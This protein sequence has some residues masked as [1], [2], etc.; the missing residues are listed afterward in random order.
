MSNF[1]IYSQGV[2]S[3]ATITVNTITEDTDFPLTNLQDRDENTLMKAGNANTSG[4]LQI[5]L[6]AARAVDYIILGNHNYTNT[7]VG[8]VVSYCDDGD[9]DFTPEVAVVGSVG[10]VTYHNYVSANADRWFE[11]F[12]QATKRYWRIY[13]QAM[14]AATNQEIGAIFMG[15][16]WNWAHEPELNPL[17]NS[18]YNVTIN[19]AAG[20]S[21][22]S[23]I[24]NTTVRRIWNYPLKF[25]SS[26]EKTNHETWRDNIFMNL[27]G[28]LSRYPF[29]W[30]EDNGVTINFARY[31]GKLNLKQHAYQQW[32]TN[33]V[34][35]EEL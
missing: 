28:G 23:Q 25:I 17:D 4:Y 15:A 1:E 16:Q 18:G 8:I 21:T 19:Q 10:P 14:G 5:D 11:T 13:L 6:A 29:Y 27:N 20:G 30:S 2:D 9:G 35:V 32:E 26:S 12:T 22:F 31:Q 7:S 34:F 24:A 33:H 3:G